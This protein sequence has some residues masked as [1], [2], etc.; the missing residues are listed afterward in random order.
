[1]KIFLRFIAF[2][3]MIYYVKT[4]FA[5]DEKIFQE[6]WGDNVRA[7]Y[8]ASDFIYNEKKIREL[9]SLVKNYNVNAIVI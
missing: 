1:M 8:L 6:N 4:T 3:L 9:E 5:E 7:I 2:A